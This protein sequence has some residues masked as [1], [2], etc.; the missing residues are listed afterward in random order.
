MT[1]EYAKLTQSKNHKKMYIFKLKK[2]IL[3]MHVKSLSFL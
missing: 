2:I 3:L 1:F